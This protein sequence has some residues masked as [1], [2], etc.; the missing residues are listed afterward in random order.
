MKNITIDMLKTG[1]MLLSHSKGFKPIA[2]AIRRLTRSYWNHV[3]YIVANGEETGPY[4][5]EA[6][7]KG[8]I[9][10]NLSDYLNGK[11]NL[12]VM[13]LRVKSFKSK[14]EYAN[15]IKLATNRMLT[16]LTNGKRYDFS[17][18][19]F[20]SFKYMFKGLF[21]KRINRFNKRERFFCSESVCYAYN[22][23]SSKIKNLFAGKKHPKA[24][25]GVITPKDIGKNCN[26]EYVCGVDKE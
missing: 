9:R 18:I 25:C 6:Q 11:Y 2:F 1:D 16:I 8:V 4:V 26:V 22:G 13:R 21:G 15:A 17:A 14:K 5:I 19:V 24:Q 3:S 10:T 23:S 20:L 12:K 7:P